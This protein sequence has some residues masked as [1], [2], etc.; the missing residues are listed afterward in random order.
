[1]GQCRIAEME[2]VPS[3]PSAALDL[4]TNNPARVKFRTFSMSA[5]L[6]L[7]F[8]QSVIL[9]GTSNTILQFILF[10]V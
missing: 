5:V 8:E 9:E 2:N 1:M 3:K 10:I 6:A 7:L 4:E